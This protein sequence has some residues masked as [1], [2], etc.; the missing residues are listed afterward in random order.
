MPT[1]Y[2]RKRI[3][4]SHR[5]ATDNFGVDKMTLLRCMKKKQADPDWAVG[6]ALTS[7]RRR[8]ILA[9]MEKDLTSHISCL[10]DMYYSLSL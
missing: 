8:I 7:L 5:K 9:D 10:A 6:Y 3:D 4:L 2:V 1:K